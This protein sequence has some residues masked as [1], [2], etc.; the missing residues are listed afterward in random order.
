M[1]SAGCNTE[2]ASIDECYLD[3]TEVARQRLAA[4]AD[5]PPPQPP[6]EQLA[7]MHICGAVGFANRSGTDSPAAPC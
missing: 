1:L 7:Q 3:V 4:T 2:R 6:P 5:R